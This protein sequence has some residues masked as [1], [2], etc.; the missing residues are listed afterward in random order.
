MYDPL[1]LDRQRQDEAQLRRRAARARRAPASRRATTERTEDGSRL[2]VLRLAFAGI[3]R[4][5]SG[6][7]ARAGC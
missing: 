3:T 2:P 7:G 1:A 6:R 4:T 5:R